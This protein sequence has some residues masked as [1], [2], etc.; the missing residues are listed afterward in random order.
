[1]LFRSGEVR[2]ARVSAVDDVGRVMNPLIAEGQIHGGIA[3]G[4][5]QAFIEQSVYDSTGQLITGSFM[6]YAMPRADLLP[7]LATG[8]DQSVPSALNP[9]GAKGVGESGCHGAMPAAVNAVLDALSDS[10]VKELDMPLTP[11]K[12]WRALRARG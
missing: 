5:G 1:M 12:V 11:E 8:F 3:Q 9:L 2:L 7:E 4:V 10:G 6:D